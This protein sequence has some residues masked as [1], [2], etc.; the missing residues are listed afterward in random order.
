MDRVLLGVET[1]Y[2][3][4]GPQDRVSQIQH[5]LQMGR[6]LL[7]CAPGLGGADLFLA[8][9]SRLYVDCLEH[10]EL[11]TPEC[12]R[13]SDVVRYIAAGELLLQR[14]CEM[15]RARSSA[16]EAIT[17]FRSN[18]DYGA[19][20][21]WGCHE[22]YLT[23][24]PPGEFVGDLVPHLISRLIYSGAGG[25]DPGAPGLVPV[26][27]PRAFYL[28]RVASAGSTA[29]RGIF[30]TKDEN[31][32]R[33]DDHR[34][35]LICGESLCSHLAAYLKCGTTALVIALIDHG[36]EPG[37]AVRPR[38][39]VSA[40]HAISNDLTCR[41]RVP[42]RDGGPASAL[43]IQRHYLEAV[44]AHLG[45]EWMPDWAEQVLDTWD[46][47]LQRLEAGPD[48]VQDRLDWAIKL[49][50]F[51]Q[52]AEFRGLPWSR[53]PVLSQ[54]ARMEAMAAAS[55]EIP[56]AARARGLFDAPEGELLWSLVSAAAPPAP[57]RAVDGLLHRHGLTRDD[58]ERFRSLRAEFL[59]IDLRFGEVGEAGIFSRLDAAGVLRHAAPGVTDIE[60]AAH[61]PP[62]DTRAHARGGAIR[63][64]AGGNGVFCDWAVLAQSNGA[65]LFF[66][67]PFAT[68]PTSRCGPT[69]RRRPDDQL[70]RPPRVPPRSEGD[71]SGGRDQ[72]G[73]P[74]SWVWH[75]I[76][77][78]A[79]AG[80]PAT[81][82]LP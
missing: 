19:R 31:L 5:L 42:L 77:E 82:R 38:G 9:G 66:D 52:H 74:G 21:T 8:N 71:P 16:G 78:L 46:E 33:T 70:W 22:S 76:R 81:D 1:E 62:A 12:R 50:L 26:L 64:F 59:E 13:P 57:V 47:V 53:I 28:R 49:A 45:A 60:G 48:A 54:A 3:A 56:P 35:H 69:S 23:R 43:Q 37:A 40:M 32:C 27:S 6:T 75:R 34:L 41:R 44:R 51:R 80:G 58:L 24:R 11:A 36:G 65:T 10:P 30:H 25:F 14:L 39:P 7:E 4:T 68:E 20:T 18:V 61:Q 17:L 72:P 67:D 15:H 79:R 2:A 73:S 55:I 29:G 63:E